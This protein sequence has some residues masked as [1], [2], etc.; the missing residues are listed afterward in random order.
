M[1]DS[2]DFIDEGPRRPRA[3]IL[4]AHGAGAGM[5]SA[6]MESLAERLVAAKLRVVRFEFPYMQ[7]QRGPRKTPTAQ[8]GT[9]TDAALA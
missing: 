4:L 6:F 2:A 8:L 7:L 9:P 1:S 5:D 3:T